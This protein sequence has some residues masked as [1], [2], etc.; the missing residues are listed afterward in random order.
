MSPEPTNTLPSEESTGERREPT[1]AV[2]VDKVARRVRV[3][4]SHRVKTPGA[5]IGVWVLGLLALLLMAALP[6]LNISIPGVL[7][8]PTY[9]PG[10]LQLL[11]M[12]LLMAAAISS[13]SRTPESTVATCSP[14]PAGAASSPS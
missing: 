10:T 1:A 12:C 4:P 7:P 11:A 6:L 9:Q 2:T 14:A 8:T 3:Q 13:R 5:R